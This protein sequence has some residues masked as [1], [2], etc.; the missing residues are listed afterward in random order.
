[1][2]DLDS[3]RSEIDAIDK[4]LVYLLDKRLDVVIKIGQYKKQNNLPICNKSREQKVMEKTTHSKHNKQVA[5]I[6]TKIIDESKD[7]Q[8]GMLKT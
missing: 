1:M 8:E 4:N 2:E 5:E 7:I 6:F 3:L